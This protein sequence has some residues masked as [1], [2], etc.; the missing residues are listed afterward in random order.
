MFVLSADKDM[1]LNESVTVPYKTPLHPSYPSCSSA[2][3]CELLCLIIVNNYVFIYQTGVQLGLQRI[4][5][6]NRL[7]RPSQVVVTRIQKQILTSQCTL[8]SSHY[9]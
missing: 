2:E 9:F 6:K 8:T 7:H 5:I 4:L 3:Y 1:Y